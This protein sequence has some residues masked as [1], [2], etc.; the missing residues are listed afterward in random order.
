MIIKVK[1]Q[2]ISNKIVL[3]VAFLLSKAEKKEKQKVPVARILPRFEAGGKGK[4]EG[5]FFDNP[6]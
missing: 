1:P 2:K 3:N 5:G 4:G 6:F